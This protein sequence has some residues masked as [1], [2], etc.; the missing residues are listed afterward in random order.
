MIDA[1]ASTAVNIEAGRAWAGNKFPTCLVRRRAR[2]AYVHGGEEK[3]KRKKNDILAVNRSKLRMW[4][5]L[6]LRCK[7][8]GSPYRQRANLNLQVTDRMMKGINSSSRLPSGQHSWSR[9]SRTNRAQESTFPE[10]SSWHFSHCISFPFLVS[11]I[12]LLAYISFLILKMSIENHSDEVN[13]SQQRYG[14]HQ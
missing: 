7:K 12:H 10:D 14:P 2:R 13:K 9:K 8:R 1:H 3:E 4:S 6:S 5:L 11:Q